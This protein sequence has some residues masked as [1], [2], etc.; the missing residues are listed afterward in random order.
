MDGTCPLSC[1]QSSPLQ[2]RFCVLRLQTTSDWIPLPSYIKKEFDLFLMWCIDMQI[3][4][5]LTWFHPVWCASFLAEFRDS[6]FWNRVSR[7]IKSVI[8]L[9]AHLSC[10]SFFLTADL[11]FANLAFFLLLCPGKIKSVICLSA[12]LSSFFRQDPREY[13]LKHSTKTYVAICDNLRMQKPGLPS[14]LLE[15]ETSLAIFP[16]L[17]IDEK[18]IFYCPFRQKL[19]KAQ[20][21]YSEMS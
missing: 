15:T 19:I 2:Q 3:N 13:A 21:I 16:F 1:C 18:C 8:C 20:T 7:K 6:Q 5:S 14:G 10:F 9:S 12:Q 17:G 4:S 11:I